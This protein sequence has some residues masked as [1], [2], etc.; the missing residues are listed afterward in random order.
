L[1][2]RVSTWLFNC[3]RCAS[4]EQ[5]FVGVLDEAERRTPAALS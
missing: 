4:T 3:F 5:S 1:K 2:E